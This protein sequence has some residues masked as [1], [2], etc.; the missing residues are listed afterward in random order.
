M[1]RL[2]KASLGERIANLRGARG[3]S[4]EALA[5]RVHVSR[6]TISN[7]ERGKTLV[8]V[9]SLAA[10]ADVLGSSVSEVLGERQVRAV[11][12]ET[13]ATRRELLVIYGALALLGIPTVA[14]GIV[15]RLGGTNMLWVWCALLVAC[16]PLAWRAWRLEHDHNL[17]TTREICR[18]VETGELPA[19]VGR[20]SRHR[21]LGLI[22]LV[23]AFLIID[24]LLDAIF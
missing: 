12:E 14:L 11:E 6:Q 15:E 21:V 10:I 16:A 20:A 5:E 23:L 8:D 2:D 13:E 22:G 17:R 7:W 24:M 18:F 3:L 1:G 19:G 9:Q 4:Q